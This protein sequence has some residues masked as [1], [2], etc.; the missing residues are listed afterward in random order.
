[1]TKK[2]LIIGCET[3]QDVEEF[4][5]EYPTIDGTIS[6]FL[7][8]QGVAHLE[9]PM[10]TAL[11]FHDLESNGMIPQYMQIADNI[12]EFASAQIE[13]G[14][15]IAMIWYGKNALMIPSVMASLVPIVPTIGVPIAKDHLIGGDTTPFVTVANARPGNPVGVVSLH[16]AK[17]PTLDRATQIAVNILNYQNETPGFANLLGS[18]AGEREENIKG[19]LDT[20]GIN[21]STLNYS[22]TSEDQK[23]MF[24]LYL[25][26]F[27]DIREQTENI[28]RISFSKTA[29]ISSRSPSDMWGYQDLRDCMNAM[30]KKTNSLYFGEPENAALFMAQIA[31]QSSPEIRDKLTKYI[32]EKKKDTKGHI[33]INDNAF[34]I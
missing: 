33:Y 30:R 22:K 5:R 3:K 16:T 34:K 1:M 29:L 21:H 28:E 15:R 20:M 7:S 23:T 2:Y 13:K 31:C 19:M 8:T 26:D 12:G 10:Q 17:T 4:N 25:L 32:A 6:K 11:T 24:G 9:S 18:K 14:N 27:V